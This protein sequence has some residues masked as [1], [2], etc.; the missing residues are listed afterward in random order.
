[1]LYQENKLTISAKNL[2]VSYI[3]EGSVP[4]PTIIFIHGFPLNKAMWDKQVG[5]LKENYRV[6]AYDIRG[7][8]NSDAGDSDFSIELFVNDLLSLMDV[9]KID[10]TILCGFSMGGY[11]A[12]NAVEN[13]PERFV[14]LLLCD[15]NCSDDKPE[16]KEK[17][18]KTIESIK[19]NGL[20]QYAEESLKKLFA[21]VSFSKQIEEIASVRE[22]IM[23]T[24]GQTLFKTL[25]ALAE[26]AETCT[27]LH[28][29]KVPVL[30]LVG[31]E[32]EITPPDAALSM[33]EK[34]KGST[35]HIIDHAGHLSNMENSIEFNNQLAGFLLL[36]K[37]K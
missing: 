2:T 19:K 23:K 35:L 12:I 5:K 30:I 13:Y 15:T 32:D 34:I 14:A 24:S 16:A 8:G 3:D 29:I 33:H 27:R 4:A 18:M 37:H 36:I 7:H 28:E 20:E 10:K 17:R 25:H 11:I 22:M 21:K 31:E 1:M 9:L 26:R 6:I